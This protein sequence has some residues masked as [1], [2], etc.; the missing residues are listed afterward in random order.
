MAKLEIINSNMKV[1]EGTAPRTS[2]LAL[3]LSLATA[4]GQGINAIT[5]SIAAIQKDMYAIEDEIQVNEAKLPIDTKL[6]EEY[7]KFIN[8]TDIANGPSNFEKN[9]PLKLFVTSF[10]LIKGV[11][12]ISSKILL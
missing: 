3:P 4:Q 6:T 1:A 2:T 10:S 11:L 5:K 9:V 12:P 7:T 8:S